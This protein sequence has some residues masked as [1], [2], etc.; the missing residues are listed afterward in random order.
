MANFFA[1]RADF[2]VVFDGNLL[3]V[4]QQVIGQLGVEAASGGL[5]DGHVGLDNN[6]GAE[7]AA[8]G[9]NLCCGKWAVGE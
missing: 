1:F 3:I 2:Q 5:A 6:F 4:I 9:V 7:M 8:Q